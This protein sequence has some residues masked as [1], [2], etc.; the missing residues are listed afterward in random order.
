MSTSGSIV[1]LYV[2]DLDP[3]GGLGSGSRPSL[4]IGKRL[5]VGS[6][7]VV[8]VSVIVFAATQALPSDPARA[9]L[10]RDATPERVSALKEQLGLN[11]PL[12]RQ[13]LS[14]LG[15]VAHGDFGESLVS[16]RSVSST[17]GEPL[18]NS[19]LLLVLTAAVAIPLSVLF[20]VLATAQRDRSMDHVLSSVSLLLIA[21]PEFVIG[22]TLVLM[23]GTT[24]FTVLPPVALVPRGESPLVHLD[25]LVLPVATL[26]LAVM[27]YLFRLVR[28][29]LIDEFESDYV[30]TARL[31]GASERRVLLRHAIPN[32]LVPA[33]QATVIILTWLLGGIVAVEFVFSYPGLGT[34]LIAAVQRRDVPVLQ[35]IVL[36]LS[37]GV[38][39]FT[40]LADLATVFL[41]PRLRS[42]LWR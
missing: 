33:V 31:K 7:T 10:G 21:I 24:V 37:T 20:A 32:A 11:E 6:V 18:R 38:V 16:Q 36:I 9:I 13:Y 42:T 39:V 30:V 5:A 26:S 2:G 29:A 1:D 23:F 28:A 3:V 4:W 15:G 34:E 35:A 22:L 27:P 14:W 41:T 8:V 25:A 12:G 19:L 40:L 17:L